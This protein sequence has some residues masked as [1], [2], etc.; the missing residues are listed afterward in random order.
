MKEEFFN[1]VKEHFEDI[2]AD[3]R[4]KYPTQYIVEYLQGY[5]QCLWDL[6]QLSPTQYKQLLK[7]ISQLTINEYMEA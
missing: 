7:H 6:E 5:S 1:E 2:I 3:M 4:I